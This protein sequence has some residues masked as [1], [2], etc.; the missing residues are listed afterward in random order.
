MAQVM[1]E[2]ERVQYTPKPHKLLHC[3]ASLETLAQWRWTARLT[4]STVLT[5][6][7]RAPGVDH[8]HT[9]PEPTFALKNSI[10]GFIIEPTNK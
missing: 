4:V 2:I 3:F 7:L 9:L 8:D 5:G 6:S 1:V 10:F